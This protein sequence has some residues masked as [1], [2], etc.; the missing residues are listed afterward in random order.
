MIV[1]QKDGMV[2]NNILSEITTNIIIN[3]QPY[4]LLIPL[5]ISYCINNENLSKYANNDILKVWKERDW[6]Y[7]KII[8]QSA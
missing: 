4:L 7:L 2:I 5:P 6:I 8:S 1:T 3:N